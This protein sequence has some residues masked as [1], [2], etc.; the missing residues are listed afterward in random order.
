MQ[1]LAANEFGG[2][3]RMSDSGEAIDCVMTT[4]CEDK[5]LPYV[6]DADKSGSDKDVIDAYGHNIFDRFVQFV[7]EVLQLITILLC[8]IMNH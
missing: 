8:T 7:S 2:K 5:E 4:V 1:K 3:S 6:L